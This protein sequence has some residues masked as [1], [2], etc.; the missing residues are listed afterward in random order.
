MMTYQDQFDKAL[1]VATLIRSPRGK[2]LFVKDAFSRFDLDDEVIGRIPRRLHGTVVVGNELWTIED[3]D[4]YESGD[5]DW[6]GETPLNLRRGASCFYVDDKSLENWD[7]NDEVY[8]EYED[9]D[10][11]KTTTS[12]YLEHDPS[13]PLLHADILFDYYPIKGNPIKTDATGVFIAIA[14]IAKRFDSEDMRLILDSAQKYYEELEARKG[15]ISVSGFELKNRSN[16]YTVGTIT[17]VKPNELRSYADRI[18][19][20]IKDYGQYL[21]GMKNP[22]GSYKYKDDT[23]ERRIRGL[24]KLFDEYFD[25]PGKPPYNVFKLNSEDMEEIIRLA[26]SKQSRGRAT[27]SAKREIAELNQFLDYMVYSGYLSRNLL[28]DID[29]DEIISE[30]SLPK[31]ERSGIDIVTMYLSF[32]RNKKHKPL[33]RDSDEYKQI[34]RI[35]KKFVR[36]LPE[37]IDFKDVTKPELLGF[38]QSEELVKKDKNAAIPVFKG[39]FDYLVSRKLIDIS[40]FAADR[41]RV[42]YEKFLTI[43]QLSRYMKRVSPK[44]REKA[45]DVF[46]TF[47]EGFSEVRGVSLESP[48]PLE[49]IKVANRMRLAASMGILYRSLRDIESDLITLSNIFSS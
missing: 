9:E 7:Y 2:T 40:P 47:A 28:D 39:F 3:E 20:L 13:K 24:N 21:L 43:P 46:R 18:D 36:K 34:S 49:I 17:L 1:E 5:D 23:V 33:E 29:T 27:K 38:A 15:I 10:I 32:L 16:S 48:T 6:E 11:M 19:T 8:D 35:L 31:E 22:D 26:L 30:F 37:Y 44:Y 14:E 41:R 4:D 12:G 45:E 42:V 25:S